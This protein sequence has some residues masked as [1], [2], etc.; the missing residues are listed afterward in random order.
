MLALSRNRFQPCIEQL[1]D[2]TVPT[3]MGTPLGNG[4]LLVTGS[5][6]VTIADDG[7]GNVTVISG[8]SS[9]TTPGINHIIVQSLETNDQIVY[10]LTGN[11]TGGQ[12]IDADLGNGP[13][14]F[15]ANIGGSLLPG[16]GMVVNVAGHTGKDI[17]G[18]SVT[19][20]LFDNAF[21]GFN[22]N[23]SNGGNT[24]SCFNVGI[25]FPGSVSLF[26][27]T[28][29]RSN[30]SFNGFFIGP[31]LPFSHVQWN[32]NVAGGNS[33]ANAYVS[34]AMSPFSSFQIGF[35]GSGSDQMNAIADNSIVAPGAFL[36]M[37]LDGGSGR[38]S[39]SDAFKGILLGT[40]VQAAFGGNSPNSISQTTLL[41]TGSSTGNGGV[42]ALEQGG[43]S[44]D[45]LFEVIRPAGLRRGIRGHVD[46]G[47]GFNIARVTPNVSVRNCQVVIH[48]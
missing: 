43:A 21:L 17:I 31:L 2:R 33:S 9:K 36:G 45:S 22:V 15:L 4:A 20:S 40:L 44:N 32:V 7:M 16:T 38:N 24:V 23:G 34:T 11:L 18:E 30:D 37:R 39:L 29:G 35:A 12:R 5:G 8:G 47:G 42:T 3:F 19:G 6:S 14:F 25:H 27:F 48:V 46:G 13:D 41:E 28:G 10:Q 1:E 26:N